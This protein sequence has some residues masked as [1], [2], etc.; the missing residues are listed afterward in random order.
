MAVREALTTLTVLLTMAEPR[1]LSVIALVTGQEGPQQK[2]YRDWSGTS[3]HSPEAIT[4][5]LVGRASHSHCGRFNS[6]AEP[7]SA[8]TAPTTRIHRS[9][10][11]SVRPRGRR[12]RYRPRKLRWTD[13]ADTAPY[14]Q[15][16]DMC[17]RM[18]GRGASSSSRSRTPR[19]SWAPACSR[20]ARVEALC[21]RPWD[22]AALPDTTAV[23]SRRADDRARACSAWRARLPGS[24][25]Q[26]VCGA[27]WLM[28]AGWLR[29][30]LSVPGHVPA[31]AATRWA[32][33]SNF[34][35][36][37]QT[38][39]TGRVSISPDSRGLSVVREMLRRSEINRLEVFMKRCLL[40]LIVPSTFLFSTSAEAWP[41]S[42]PPPLPKFVV[43][44]LSRPW[45]KG[46]PVPRTKSEHE[47]QVSEHQ[48][49][50][51]A[52]VVEVSTL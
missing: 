28:G 40:C 10:T 37:V 42:L 46:G 6:A 39:R 15:A 18:G 11:A 12:D 35:H 27:G 36:Q 52:H 22:R 16:T 7:T 38:K 44:A 45:P 9:D 30:C 33:S 31:R 4:V 8:L 2:G 49:Q 13:S 14:G 48:V 24:A 43:L 32:S 29:G 26:K 19:T 51:V 25:T 20:S 5:A 3:K 21:N 41:A 23:S 34:D 47:A 50:R 17:F 1:G